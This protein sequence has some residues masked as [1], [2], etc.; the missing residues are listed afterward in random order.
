MTPEVFLGL[1]CIMIEYIFDI[2]QWTIINPI[3]YIY[4]CFF[5]PLKNMY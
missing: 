3:S 4:V 1:K 2:I 5:I